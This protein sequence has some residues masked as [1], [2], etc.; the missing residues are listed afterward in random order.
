MKQDLPASRSSTVGPKCW[1]LFC[2]VASLIKC[3]KF[4]GGGGGVVAYLIVNLDPHIVKVKAKF[5]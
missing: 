4:S 5:V 1:F 3:Q 2:L